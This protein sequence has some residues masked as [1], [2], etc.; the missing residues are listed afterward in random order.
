MISVGKKRIE[1]LLKKGL[2]ELHLTPDDNYISSFLTYLIE[3]KKWNKVYNLTSIKKDED[4]IIKHFLDSLLYMKGIP[5]GA[6]KI[7]DIGSGAGFPGIPIKIIRP[8][9][10]MYLIES[11]VKKFLFLRHIANLLKIKHIEVI[12]DRVENIK[13]TLCVDV[14]MTRALFTVEEFIKRAS[15]IIKKGGMLIHSKG[16]KIQEELQKLKDINY[17]IIPCTL[18]LTDIQRYIV[19]VKI[20]DSLRQDCSP[21]R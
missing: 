20:E 14:A 6:L 3:L 7:A 16:P 1:E 17:E 2:E 5:Q 19:T 9:V 4:I 18:P 10:D 13:K 15:H 21:A 8:E 11:S 12:E